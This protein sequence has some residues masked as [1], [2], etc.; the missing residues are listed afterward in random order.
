MNKRFLFK[1][2]L[3]FLLST[4][5]LIA[6]AYLFGAITPRTWEQGEASDAS[7]APSYTTV[8]L[9][10]GHGGEDGGASSASGL[11]EKD[12]NLDVA[13]KTRDLLRASGVE[14][15]MTREDDRLLYDP[16]SDYHGQMKK[17]D[18]ATRLSVTEQTEGAILVSIHMNYFPDSR[19]GGLQ[20]WYSPNSADSLLLADTVQ[21]NARKLLQP[22]N[23]RQTKSAGSSIFLLH[24]AKCPAVLVECGFL[25]NEEEASRL[26]SEEYRQ[27]VAFTLFCSIMEFLDK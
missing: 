19:Y 16:S 14:V 17:Q 21:G 26:A 12:L 13:L 10:A 23:K 3:F 7:A 20:V 18:L 1:A 22:D 2:L 4:A 6:L 25:S 5:L 15:V 27:K 9:D 8:I 24:R 11:L